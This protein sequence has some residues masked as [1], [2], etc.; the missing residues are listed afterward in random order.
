MNEQ[1]FEKLL[2]QVLKAPAPPAGLQNALLAIADEES[3][4]SALPLTRAAANDSWW[5]RALPVAACMAL[6]LGLA[7]RYQP[8]QETDTPL[9]QEIL[10]HVYAEERFLNSGEH[11]SLAD[12]NSRMSSVIKA[13][14]ESSPATD[15]MQVH[16][17]KDCWIAQQ[18]AMH[19]II[20]GDTGPVSVMM[21]PSQM[22][23]KETTFSDDRFT[24]TITPMGNG[25]LVV[26][27]NRKEPMRKYSSMMSNNLHWEY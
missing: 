19:L 20:S 25:T 17:S 27:G 2:Q 10:R 22:V 21:I 7:Y 3:R 11:V 9:T 12:V 26:L 6:L 5:R 24:G 1:D 16:F 13:Q 14:L 4:V 8:A 18:A 15:A 23:E